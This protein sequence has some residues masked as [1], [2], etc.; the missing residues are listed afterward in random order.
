MYVLESRSINAQDT[1]FHNKNRTYISL[2]DNIAP[3][4]RKK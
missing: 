4:P 1:M 3:S 2:D